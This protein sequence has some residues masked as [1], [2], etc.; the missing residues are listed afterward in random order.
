MNKDWHGIMKVIEIE[1]IRNG[2][3]IWSKK[4]LHNLLHSDGEGYFLEVL[5]RNPNNGTMPPEFYYLGL[6][7]RPSIAVSDTMA[8]LVDEPTTNGYF[9]QVVSSKPDQ[10]TGWYI[11]ANDG[12]TKALC[13]IITFTAAGGSW[14]PVNNL[15]LTTQNNNSGYLIS[16]VSLSDEAYLD[17]G[18][19]INLRMAMTLRDC[20]LS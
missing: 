2:K 17:D 11:V 1:Q 8:S 10:S 16:S 3:V 13:S 6:D 4:N 12:Y 18:D 19:V 20:P 15:F 14:G 7:A 9:R 5:F